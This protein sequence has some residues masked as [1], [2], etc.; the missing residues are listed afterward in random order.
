MTEITNSPENSNVETRIIPGLKSAYEIVSLPFWAW[1]WLDDFMVKHRVSYTGIYDTFGQNG[2]FEHTL[3]QIAELHHEHAMREV[4]KLA[5]DNE[6]QDE[7]YAEI[8][9]R[10]VGTK[11]KKAINNINLP[12]IYKLF[13]FMPCATTLEA[14]WERRNYKDQNKVN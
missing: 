5:N 13:G 8:L 11:K 3:K 14:V 2:D 6:A 4:Y 1:F 12:H 7:H 9:S 10:P